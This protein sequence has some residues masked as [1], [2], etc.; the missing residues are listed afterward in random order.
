MGALYSQNNPS[1]LYL[2][3]PYFRTCPNVAARSPLKYPNYDWRATDTPLFLVLL[4]GGG[5]LLLLLLLLPL[6][7]LVVVLAGRRTSRSTSA[8]RALSPL[9]LIVSSQ[10]VWCSLP[11]KYQVPSRRPLQLARYGEETLIYCLNCGFSKGNNIVPI[12]TIFFR[13]TLR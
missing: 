9:T 1:S 7:L 13:G 8:Y 12:G 4:A 10:S 2:P 3:A 6:L 5:G 11:L